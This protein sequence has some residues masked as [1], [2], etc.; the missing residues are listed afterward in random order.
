MRRWMKMICCLCWSLGAGSIWGA[1]GRLTILHTGDLAGQFQQIMKVGALKQHI[2]HAVGRVVLL[3][4][5]NALS[6][7]ERVFEHP[8][9]KMSPT[10]DLMNRAGYDAWMLGQ[11]DLSLPQADLTDVL[12]EA[13]FPVLGA[14]LHRPQTGRM[15]FQVQPYA[16]I[17]TGGIRVGVLGL[18]GGGVEVGDPVLAAQYYV[19]LMRTQAHVVVLLTH[20][21]PEQDSRLAEMVPGI[22]LIVATTSSPEGREAHPIYQAGPG[23][24]SAGRIDLDLTSEGGVQVRNATRVPLDVPV[25]PVD[26]M[27]GALSAW[28]VPIAGESRSVTSVLG[29]SSGG[30][31]ASVGLA[32][33]MGYLVADLMR[34]ATGADVALVSA[35]SL[36]TELPEGSISVQD[37]FRIYGPEHQVV[38]VQLTGEELRAIMETG[39]DDLA[40][41]F[42]PSGLEV[43][44]DLSQSRG[45]RLS[46]LTLSGREPINL[47]KTFR[48]AVENGVGR[49]QEA[50]RGKSGPKVRDLLALH[51][52]QAG[53]IQG[54][55]DNRLREP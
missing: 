51:I 11:A 41:F 43:F 26:A 42:Y 12:R 38:V 15:L 45:H 2:Q 34:A 7:Y 31:G 9:R 40:A 10:V 30:F 24:H 54:V 28:M 23:G 27:G 25:G 20:L 55:I 3:D 49:F 39:L 13:A 44:F 29:R 19:P 47:R 5:G 17:Q 1:E 32:G 50:A 16:I 14:N 33:A 37:V 52:L 48:V 6:P 22:D 4:A 35:M 8:E 36:D 53:A 46:A 21:P 18:G